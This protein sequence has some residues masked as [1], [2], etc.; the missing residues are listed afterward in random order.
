MARSARISSEGLLYHIFSR[1]NNREPIF[2]ESSNYLRF[3][4]N[5]DRFQSAYSYKVYGYCLMPNHFHLLLETKFPNISKIMQVVMT[6]YTMYLNKKY[7]RVGHVFQGR[8]KSI[9][10]QKEN[11][12]LQVLR[13]IH[14]NPVKSG[15]VPTPEG[16]PWSSYHAYLTPAPHKVT[17]ATDD[18]LSLYSPNLKRSRVLFEEHTR[19]T[20]MPEFDPFQMQVRSV[21]GDEKFA[22][23]LTKVLRGS[24]P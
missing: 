10:V 5:L 7:N 22:M 12:L 11:Y 20:D 24:R 4:S 6:A 14:L 23:K 3:L 16:Y 8:F 2:L 1:G 17:L 13:Y 9:V 21:I 15:L 19:E 18:V